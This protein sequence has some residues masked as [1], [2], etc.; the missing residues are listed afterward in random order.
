M[1]RNMGTDSA[2]ESVNKKQENVIDCSKACHRTTREPLQL[3]P[4]VRAAV[5]AGPGLCSS[6]PR[7]MD[8]PAVP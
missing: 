4:P 3:A 7:D 6:A 1:Y 8:W 2:F 5:K